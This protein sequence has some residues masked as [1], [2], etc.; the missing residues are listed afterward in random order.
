MICSVL[1]LNF[2][3]TFDIL[4][5]KAGLIYLPKPIWINRD[6]NVDLKLAEGTNKE[7]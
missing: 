1:E 5:Q 3:K 7:L 2:N 6:I 4:Y